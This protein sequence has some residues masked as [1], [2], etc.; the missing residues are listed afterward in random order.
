[1]NAPNETHQRGCTPQ[2]SPAET[3][4]QPAPPRDRAA[5]G[6]PVLPPVR[7]RTGHPPSRTPV[8]RPPP[9]RAARCPHAAAR[10]P[11]PPDPCWPPSRAW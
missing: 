1:M 5:L 4:K 2:R 3:P 6:P 7:A 9:D 10:A 8:T 11:A